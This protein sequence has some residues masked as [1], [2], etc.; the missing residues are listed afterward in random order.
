MKKNEFDVLQKPELPQADNGG[1]PGVIDISLLTTEFV[2]A[3]AWPWDTTDGGIGPRPYD[4]YI[5]YFNDDIWTSNIV[6]DLDE[7][8]WPVYPVLFHKGEIPDGVYNVYYTVQDYA[9][10]PIASSSSTKVTIIGASAPAYPSPTFPDFTD[11]RAPFTG[12]TKRRGVRIEATYP[13]ISPGDSVEFNWH[14]TDFDGDPVPASQFRFEVQ[15]GSGDQKAACVIPEHA[16]LCLGPGGKGTAYY[17]VTPSD[18]DNGGGDSLPASLRI[19]FS[20]IV[21][22]ELNVSQGAPVTLPGTVLQGMNRVRLFGAPGMS[23]YAS[24]I[25]GTP[26]RIVESGNLDYSFNLD[27]QGMGSLGVWP[28][29]DYNPTLTVS[30]DHVPSPPQALVFR[31]AQSELNSPIT[32]GYTSG[33]AADDPMFGLDPSYCTVYVK[34]DRSLSQAEC[35]YVTVDGAA[36]LRGNSKAQAQKAPVPLNDFNGTAS[37]DIIDTRSETVN[38]TLS[39]KQ[40]TPDVTFTLTFEP[41]PSWKKHD[42]IITDDKPSPAS[43]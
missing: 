35:V 1:T 13:H 26:A 22:L 16:V 6:A 43:S 15:V 8:H 27:Q 25:S 28:N 9:Q 31:D 10:N 38:V 23:V 36:F 20:D 33:A 30:G 32:Y 40:G 41:F 34:V 21:K 17:H 24:L 3:Y 14:G 12:V 5:M 29:G 7:A 2:V 37:F 18:P 11:G 4:T 19:S 42:W 39:L